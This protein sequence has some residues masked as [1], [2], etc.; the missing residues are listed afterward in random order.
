MLG[1]RRVEGSSGRLWGRLWGVGSWGKGLRRVACS[2]GVLL[3][4][5]GCTPAQEGSSAPMP[6]VQ[7]PAAVASPSSL[8][9]TF[10]VERYPYTAQHIQTAIKEGHP[11]TCTIDR[12][13]AKE[14]R[15][16]S[17]RG[18]ETKEG[19]DRDEWPMAMCAEGGEGAS[20]EY[21]PLSDN[22]GAG[23]WVGN[24]LRDVED[25]TIVTFDFSGD[26]NVVLDSIKEKEAKAEED[27]KKK[28]QEA[29]N[30]KKEQ[31]E[32]A[33]A[34]AEQ[35]EQDRLADEQAEQDRLA[36]ESANSTPAKDPNF[37]FENCM[38]V[39]E[40]GAAPIYPGDYGWD[41]KFDR[42]QDGVGCE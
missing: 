2:A 10:P 7:E 20:V 23:S 32:A 19:Y 15:K 26:D 36:E 41:E 24:R 40:A 34:K 3:V 39:R 12:D 11:N 29:A 37:V 42:D 25:G 9:L 4:V 17:L 6:E 35:A 22:R 8:T 27:R 14:N 33:R 38:A 28:E 1:V 31:E 16:L 18:I 21:V 5:A 30:K 13:G